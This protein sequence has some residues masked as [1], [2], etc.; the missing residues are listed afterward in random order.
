MLAAIV[1]IVGSIYA[2]SYPDAN[3][4]VWDDQTHYERT[5]IVSHF[6]MDNAPL[7]EADRILINSAYQRSAGL[8]P[9]N[10]ARVF[11][12]TVNETY[13]TGEKYSAAYDQPLYGQPLTYLP[14]AMMLLAGRGLCFQYSTTFT[15]GRW[16][17][18]L[19]YS[20]LVF[21]ALRRLKTGKL[22]FFVISMF[23]TTLVL[24][25]DYSYDTWGLGF[26]LLSF[27]LWLEVMQ[28]EQ[29]HLTPKR[30]T[31][32]CLL[33]VLSCAAKPVY[34]LMILVFLLTPA[35]RLDDSLNLRTFR[36]VII[37]TAV[38]LVAS[39]VIPFLSSG[40]GGNDYRG[41]SDVNSFK[42]VHYIL[43]N[44]LTYAGVLLNFLKE[45]WT[46]GYYIYSLAYLGNAP[47]SFLILLPML[48]IAF[49]DKSDADRTAICFKNSAVSIILAVA[50]SALIA[51]SL[52][53]SFTP[54]GL[55][56]FNGCQPR[57][58]LP[59]L[60]FVAYF[61]GGRRIAEAVKKLVPIKMLVVFTA[62]YMTVYSCAAIYNHCLLVF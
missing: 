53:V 49:L 30:L 59:L 38:L 57:Y 15:L 18:T 10:E 39:F 9:N 21:L 47:H 16:A 37:L 48:I 52:Y 22:I 55:N 46:S 13:L 20:L 54:V 40:A 56:K 33:F 5:V 29:V 23:P 45:Y 58:L 24:M 17:N 1:L 50:T 3:L 43:S 25:S 60:P 44:P 7:S 62:V 11:S 26:T 41:G 8:L 32:I 31:A 42:Q 28:N 51:T 6:N 34:F 36:I 35:S 19:F 14:A 2:F 27:A 12:D 61:L 4:V